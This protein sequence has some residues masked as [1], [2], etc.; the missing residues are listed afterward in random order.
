MPTQCKRRFDASGPQTAVTP[1]PIIRTCNFCGTTPAR[2]HC[3]RCRKVRYCNAVCQAAHW[4][5][6]TDPHKG[7][8]CRAA[9]ESQEEAGGHPARPAHP[10]HSAHPDHP[11]WS[12]HHPALPAHPG[13][14]AQ[15]G[16]SG[17]DRPRPLA[18]CCNVP[19]ACD[20]ASRGCLQRAVASEHRPARPALPARPRAV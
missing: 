7:H 11:D 4:N 18:G 19:G 1:W 12:R 10:A 2:Q 8:C 3:A 13:H 17:R 5:R 16:R 14:H 9:E 20:R 6:E 15:P